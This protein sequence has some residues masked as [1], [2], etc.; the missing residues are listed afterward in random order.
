MLITTSLLVE[1]FL[2]FLIAHTE[3]VTWHELKRTHLQWVRDLRPLVQEQL[4]YTAELSVRE[5]ETFH[6]VLRRILVPRTVG[7][8]GHAQVRHFVRSSLED[9]DWHVEEDA[10]KAVTP[11][12]TKTFSNVVATLDPLACH[13]LVLACHYDSMIP[14]YGEFLGATDSAVPCAQLI[15]LAAVL[16]DKL[17][18]QKRRGDGLTLQLIFF[19]GEE[20]FVRW[21]SSDS[22][23]GSRHLASMWHQ[24]S[25]RGLPLDGCLPRSDIA[26]QIDRMEV[27]VLLDL[28]GAANPRFYSYFVDTRLVYDRFV[29]IES[30]L[31]DVGAMETSCSRCH[32]NYFVNS[33]QLAL[34]EDDHIPFLR[35]TLS[36]GKSPSDTRPHGSENE[37]T[38]QSTRWVCVQ[39]S[40]DG[41]GTFQVLTAIDMRMHHSQG[42][43]MCPSCT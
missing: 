26:T 16:D 18:E 32:T 13:R 43:Q 41:A 1:V 5:Q 30:R 23:Y 31:N 4:L 19:D 21:S 3:G 9:L 14:K 15:Y 28:L 2:A 40:N 11:L 29:D 38:V 42:N 35:K 12:G 33:S 34:I 36:N 17:K 39:D 20:A 25:T 10:F 7:S 37:Q 27:L 6:D 8:E 24:N 22:L